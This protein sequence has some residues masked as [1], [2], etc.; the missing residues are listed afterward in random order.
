MAPNGVVRVVQSVPMNIPE[1][2][3]TKLLVPP[4]GRDLVE[5]P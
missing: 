2:L 4:V 3:K 1:L 5:R